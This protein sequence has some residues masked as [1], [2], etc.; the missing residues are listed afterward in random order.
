M[1]T[2]SSPV[3]TTTLS[4]YPPPTPSPLPPYTCATPSPLSLYARS[5][6]QKS[7][8]FGRGVVLTLGGCGSKGAGDFGRVLLR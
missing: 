5:G 6:E 2:G 8:D 1:S 3:H 4:T 7:W